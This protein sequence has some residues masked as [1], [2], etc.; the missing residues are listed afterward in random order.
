[1]I[2]FVFQCAWSQ[3]KTEIEKRIKTDAV[4]PIALKDLNKQ[5]QNSSRVKWYYQEDGSKK[6]YEAKFKHHSKKYSVEF[7]T[8]GKIYNVEVEIKP[9]NIDK[10]VLKQIKITLKNQW[11][12][13]KI[14]KIQREFLGKSKGLFQVIFDDEIDDDL[15]IHY[16]INVYAKV[17]KKRKL[18]EILYNSNGEIISQREAQLKSTDILDY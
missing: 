1:M 3:T 18:F 10:Q 17:G 7:D 14:R 6:V 16:E 13:F 4:P 12:N 9:K 15:T 8:I 5:L 2:L 11:D